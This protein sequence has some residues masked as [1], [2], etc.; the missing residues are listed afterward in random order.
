[1]KKIIYTIILVMCINLLDAQVIYEE[2]ESYKLGETRE[3]KI[4]LPR[5]Y[6][7]NA[8]KAIHCL[9]Y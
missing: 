3:I 4:Q 9:S 6:D 8:D 5:G 2:F 1:M 7:G